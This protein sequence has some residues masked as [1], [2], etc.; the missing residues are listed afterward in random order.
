MIA[1]SQRRRRLT[2]GNSDLL[3]LTASVEMS[4][5]TTSF[6]RQVMTLSIAFNA[7]IN[8]GVFGT[9]FYWLHCR[10][11]VLVLKWNVVVVVL[12]FVYSVLFVSPTVFDVSFFTFQILVYRIKTVLTSCANCNVIW[13]LRIAVSFTFWNFCITNIFGIVESVTRFALHTFVLVH[14]IHCAIWNNSHR[15]TSCW[16]R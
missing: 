5:R 12:A 1:R 2:V 9:A 4:I 15:W 8:I 13:C 14:W 10:T 3:A 11:F 16:C 7:S 6:S